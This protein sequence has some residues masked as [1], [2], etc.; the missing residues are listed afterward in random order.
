M[1]YNIIIKFNLFI[2]FYFALFLFN[3]YTAIFQ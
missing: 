2:I 1:Y 3:S